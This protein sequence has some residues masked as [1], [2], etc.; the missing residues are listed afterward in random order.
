MTRSREQGG[1]NSKPPP[2]LYHA[3]A[4]G[5]Q[6]ALAGGA[7]KLCV[8]WVVRWGAPGELRLAWLS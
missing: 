4:A 7:D 2:G 5:G 8:V 6:A 3:R 1:A